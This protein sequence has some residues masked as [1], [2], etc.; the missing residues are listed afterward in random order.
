MSGRGWFGEWRSEVAVSVVRVPRRQVAC[1]SLVSP[2]VAT[3]KRLRDVRP[4]YRA[5]DGKRVPSVTTVI[6]VIAK[7]Y[8]VAWGNKLGLQGINSTEFVNE[9]AGAGTI[10][11][12][13][14]EAA[15]K[16]VPMDP[17]LIA[18]FSD[19]ERA[20]G[21][22]AWANFK[23]WRATH[24]VEPI[25]LERQVVS[26][27]MRVGGT[28]DLYARVDGRRC[29]VDFKTSERVYESH[30]VQLAA[31]RALLEETGHEVDE[32]RV[33]LVPREPLVL[34]YEGE[35]VVTDTRHELDV[36]RAARGLYEAQRL[37][38]AK[39]RQN[40]KAEK[41][42]RLQAVTDTEINWQRFSD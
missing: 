18:E 40:R 37:M 34:D 3:P 41:E 26:E 5:A 8:L 32:V 6:G 30:L 28:V 33:V 39:Q 10:A 14:I 42:Q 25:F 2:L 16:G 1:V 35:R 12:A 27:T 13:A 31:Y 15:F 23:K 19:E 11:H 7:P 17:A 24:E 29:V 20:A 21:R 9:A 36:F 4:V 38:E 22:I